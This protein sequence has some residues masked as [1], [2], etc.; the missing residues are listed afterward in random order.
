[1]IYLKKEKAY[2]DVTK[3]WLAKPKSNKKII[4]FD[5]EF[6]DDFGIKH[7]IKNKEKSHYAQMDSEEYRIAL[8]L[9]NIFGGEIHM[10]PRITDISNTG[11]STPT[12]DY[13]WNGDK[14]DLK[15]PVIDGKFENTFERFVKKRNARIQAENFIVYYTHFPDRSRTEIISVINNTLRNPHRYWI[16]NVIII[17]DYNVIK[18]YCKKNELLDE[19]RPN[20]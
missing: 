16:K 1:M 11:L 15:T 6:I 10:V 9:M 2:K 14:W 17:K 20:R 7:P 3:E 12:P 5:K 8:L 13:I 19:Q 18:I 4:L